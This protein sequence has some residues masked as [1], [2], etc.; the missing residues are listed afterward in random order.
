MIDRAV[1]AAAAHKGLSLRF[2]PSLV[3]ALAAPAGAVMGGAMAGGRGAVVGL[4]VAVAGP[5]AAIRLAPDQRPAQ[6]SAQVPEFLDAVARSLRAGRSLVG[7]VGATIDELREPLAAEVRAVWLRVE[8]GVPLPDALRGLASRGRAT[9]ALPTAAA[10]LL[11][12]REAGGPQAMV[13]DGLAASLRARQAAR[14]ELRA[15]TMPVRA[16]ASLIAVAPVVAFVVMV[17]LDRHTASRAFASSAGRIAAVAGGVLDV[18]G[19][20]WI[21]RLI[22]GVR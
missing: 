19:L 13:L 15:L 21:R 6:V 7:A 12:A 22:R 9:D 3:L 4:F 14:R 2:A 5:V 18:V 8:A 16:S 20:W 11:I 10:A 17:T 1:R